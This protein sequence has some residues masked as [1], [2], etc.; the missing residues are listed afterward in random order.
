[1]TITRTFDV[2]LMDLDDT[3]YRVPEIPKKM[4]ERIKDYMAEKL[5]I[6]DVEKV[7]KDL[8]IRYGTT[9]AGL[10]SE[11]FNID[12]DDWHRYTHWE[13]PYSSYLHP[14]PELQAVL[15]RIQLPMFIFTN[16]DR[17]HAHLCLKHLNLQN[18]F[19]EI[20][21]FE[22]IQSRAREEGLLG[23]AEKRL[24]CK[25]SKEAFLLALVQAGIKD[26]SRCIF[27]DD[28]PSNVA[29]AHEM[30]IYS[31]LVGD[32][33]PPEQCDLVIPSLDH[34][35]KVLPQLMSSEMLG[36]LTSSQN[37]GTKHEEALASVVVEA[38]V[39]ENSFSALQL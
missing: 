11:G 10:V 33:E 4:F 24:I 29:A 23:H 26:R 36:G 3:L 5:G 14:S 8:Y 31:V 7:A 21:C 9:V 6:G 30:G 17:K 15:D 34:I 16:A 12:M 32:K 39:H 27:F 38:T 2:I 1:M 18:Y 13:L 22:S 28:S 37:V 35:P 25:P 20:I 19:Q